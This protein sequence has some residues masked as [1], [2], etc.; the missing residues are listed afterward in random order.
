MKG[1]HPLLGGRGNVSLNIKMSCLLLNWWWQI[2]NCL[3]QVWESLSAYLKTNRKYRLDI[4]T[5]RS[6]RIVTCLFWQVPPGALFWI[7]KY[8]SFHSLTY[9]QWIWFTETKMSIISNS[10]KPCRLELSHTNEVFRLYPIKPPIPTSW[11]CMNFV[12]VRSMCP[13][14]K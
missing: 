12:A 2:W 10:N 14:R 8:F 11:P 6:K 1:W 4:C 3:G 7:G 5:L 13:Y 9:C